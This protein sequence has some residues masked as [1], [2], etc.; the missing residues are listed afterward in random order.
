M[1]DNVPTK[2]CDDIELTAKTPFEMLE[3]QASLIEWCDKKLTVLN[4]DA[5]ELE[6]ATAHA[7]KNKW[8]WQVHDKHHKLA[9]KRVEYYEKIRGA[10]MNGYYIVPNF[11]ISFFA[12]K[13]NKHQPKK[14]YGTYNWAKEQHPQSLAIGEGEYKNPFPNRMQ[15]TKTDDKGR[16]ETYTWATSWQ[17]EI[18]FPVSMAKPM[19]MGATSH[20]MALKIFDRFGI[21][22][23]A[24]TRGGDPAIIGQI[25]TKQ[26]GYVKKVVSFMVAWHLNT[27]VL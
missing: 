21:L 6:E 27:N 24:A 16:Q 11:P 7:K 22:P 18:D 14:L 1:S 3:A 2:V 19:I 10:L 23:A 5:K 12:I 26:N 25:V 15:E 4:N 13:T 8:R 17:D 20:A 9:L